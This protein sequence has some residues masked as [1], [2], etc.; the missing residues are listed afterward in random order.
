M[1]EPERSVKIVIPAAGQ[2]TRLQPHTF[3]RPKVM[4]P[5]AGRPI[6]GHILEDVSHLGAEEI[7]LVVGYMGETV[8]EY[9]REAFPDLPIRLVWQERQLGLGHAVLQ[10][11]DEGDADPVLVVLGDTVFDVDYAAVIARDVHVLGVRKV[12]DPERF[13]IVELDDSGERIVRLIEKPTDPPTDLALVGLYWVR[14]GELLRS[15][16]AGLVGEDVTTRGEYQL[17]DALQRLIDA[18][19]P[20]APYEIGDWFDCGKPETLLSTNRALLDRENPSLP[21][22]LHGTA[23][24]LV[25][26]VWIGRGCTIENAVVGPHVTVMDGSTVRNAVVRDSI[27][28]SGSRIEDAILTG[29]IVGP[30]AVVE[31]RP[32]EIDIGDGSDVSC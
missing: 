25:P 13:G 4:L 30:D 12:P 19:E 1:T 2:G 3:T 11:I 29:S 20:F 9:A 16:I 23:A 24:A 14:S 21:D 10:A 17:T 27:L 18:G 26:P 7:R 15:A 6:I 5:V 31:G 22:D 28:A 32:L 8:G